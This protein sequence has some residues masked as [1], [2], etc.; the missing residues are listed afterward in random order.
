MRKRN[1]PTTFPF[2]FFSSLRS[3]FFSFWSIVGGA[4]KQKKSRTHFFLNASFRG[5]RTAKD[6]DHDSIFLEAVCTPTFCFCE[7]KKEAYRR[8][9]PHVDMAEGRRRKK[10]FFWEMKSWREH[11]E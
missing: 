7:C 1:S 4:Q 9:T 8:K 3:I 2:S 5:C 11:W 6:R 10:A